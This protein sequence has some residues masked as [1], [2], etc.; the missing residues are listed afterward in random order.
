MWAMRWRVDQGGAKLLETLVAL[1]LRE[2]LVCGTRN[3][4]RVTN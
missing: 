4:N 3:L 2:H 1:S